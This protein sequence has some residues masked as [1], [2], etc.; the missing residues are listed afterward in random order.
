MGDLPEK[1]PEGQVQRPVAA[2]GVGALV[3]LGEEVGGDP[4]FEEEL[5]LVQEGGLVGS[6]LATEPVEVVSEEWSEGREIGCHIRQLLYCP[7]DTNANL[8]W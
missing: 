5:E 7:I 1:G 6:T 8:K 4:A 3:A 2:T